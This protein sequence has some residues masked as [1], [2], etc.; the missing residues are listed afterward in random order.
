MHLDLCLVTREVEGDTL[1]PD[2]LAEALVDFKEDLGK[3][4]EGFEVKNA[5]EDDDA[6]DVASAILDIE[7]LR[8]EMEEETKKAKEITL[9]DYEVILHRRFNSFLDLGMSIPVAIASLHRV[10][11]RDIFR[12]RD[13]FWQFLG[14]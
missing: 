14:S 1:S 7:H 3:Y 9:D 11:G 13:E 10:E 2:R 12:V 8:K 5:E 4:L 6:Q